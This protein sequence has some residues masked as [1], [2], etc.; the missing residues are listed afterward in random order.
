MPT[1]EEGIK[2][3]FKDVLLR[4]KRSILKSRADVDLNRDFKFRNSEHTYHGIPVI[5]ANMDTIGTFEMAVALNKVT[6]KT[7]KFQYF[8]FSTDILFFFFFQIFFSFY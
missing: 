4:P 2:L 1:I 3:D 7:K 6:K 5:A 8:F